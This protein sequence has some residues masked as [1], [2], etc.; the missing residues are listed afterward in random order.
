MARQSSNAGSPRRFF[1]DSSQLTNFILDSGATSHRTPDIL[2]LI[3][4]LLV[5]KDK[6]TEVSDG[7]FV[8]VKQTGEVKMKFMT[9]MAKTSLLRYKMYYLHQTCEIKYF[10]LS[11]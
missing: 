1:G 10:P 2:D 3:P 5:K 6:Y 4:D 9:M 8:T 11:G 7:N